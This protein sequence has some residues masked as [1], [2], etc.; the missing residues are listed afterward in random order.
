[1]NIYQSDTCRKDLSWLDL[2]DEPTVQERQQ[3]KNQQLYHQFRHDKNIPC[4]VIMV[5]LK[6]YRAT[7]GERNFIEQIKA[8]IL[9]IEIM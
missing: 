1:M 6:R 3:V 7:S 8:S 4:K 9:A 5:D 2:D